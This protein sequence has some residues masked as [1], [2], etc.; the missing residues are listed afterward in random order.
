MDRLSINH[1]QG[2]SLLNC[3]KMMYPVLQK[4]EQFIDRGVSNK[5]NDSQQ[6]F[7]IRN[8]INVD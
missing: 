6:P 1:E 4:E 8:T 5:I 3:Y 7:N 2:R